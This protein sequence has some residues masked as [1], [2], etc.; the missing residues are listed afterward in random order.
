MAPDIQR[1]HATIGCL[2]AAS[3][4]VNAGGDDDLRL[5]FTI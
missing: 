1:E 3:M 2:S 4:R 5:L